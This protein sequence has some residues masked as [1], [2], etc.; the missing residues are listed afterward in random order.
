MRLRVLLILSIARSL[1][2]RK[3]FNI[4]MPPNLYLHDRNSIYL[5]FRV[6]QCRVKGN[7][8]L[9]LLMHLIFTRFPE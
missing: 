5:S 2:L 8:T 7:A 4:S 9:Y 1:V 3:L 6:T